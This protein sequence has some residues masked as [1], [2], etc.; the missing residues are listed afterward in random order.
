MRKYSIRNT[1]QPNPIH[2]DLIPINEL[3]IKD[4]QE[5]MIMGI[6]KYGMPLTPNNGRDP[7]L[8]AYQE[9]MDLVLYI[10]QALYEHYG[11]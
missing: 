4:L 2:N 1:E 9:A 8:D 11:E 3:V 6:E 10:R 7:L 5:R